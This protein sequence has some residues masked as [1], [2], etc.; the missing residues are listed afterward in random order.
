MFLGHW[1][2]SFATMAL[3]ASTGRGHLWPLVALDFRRVVYAI[4]G[5]FPADI[6]YMDRRH[7]TSTISNPVGGMDR[8]GAFDGLK[9]P[10]RLG[11]VVAV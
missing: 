10:V 11:H 4:C 6:L 2:R 9:L 5:P 7:R 1:V 3:R 8:R